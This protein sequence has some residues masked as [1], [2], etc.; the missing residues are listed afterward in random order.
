ME[1]DY[2]RL[3]LKVRGRSNLISIG[4]P[5]GA[6]P[7]RAWPTYWLSCVGEDYREPGCPQLAQTTSRCTM[8]MCVRKSPNASGRY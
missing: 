7:A 4:W 5:K 3:S 2:L 6:I 8:V 1:A